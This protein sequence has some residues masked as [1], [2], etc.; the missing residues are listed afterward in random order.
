MLWVSDK[1]LLSRCRLTSRIIQLR[2]NS[3]ISIAAWLRFMK[4]NKFPGLDKF[5]ICADRF[6]ARKMVV[7]ACSCTQNYVSIKQ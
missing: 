1:I 6:R 3:I 4:D 2:L 5:N 7:R